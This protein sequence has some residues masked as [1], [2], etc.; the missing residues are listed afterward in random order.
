ML[1]V[2]YIARELRRQE[3]HSD[4]TGYTENYTRAE[5]ED[6][7]RMV[8]GD[9][10]HLSLVPIHYIKSTL[11]T[12]PVRR[13]RQIIELDTDHRRLHIQIKQ[14]VT[15]IQCDRPLPGIFVARGQGPQ[16]GHWILDGHRRLLAHRLAKVPVIRAYHPVGPFDHKASKT[17]DGSPVTNPLPKYVHGEHCGKR[18][19]NQGDREG[20]PERHFIE[21]E[22]LERHTEGRAY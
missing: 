18:V 4:F 5:L 20:Y 17:W 13:I 16:G 21:R 9:R 6:L 10:W 3:K 1:S 12:V 8:G 7:L 22:H 2:A 19:I 15:K 11:T 14:L